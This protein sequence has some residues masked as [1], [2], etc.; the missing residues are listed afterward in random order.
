MSTFLGTV[1]SWPEK[2]LTSQHVISIFARAHTGNV[3]GWAIPSSA[4]LLRARVAASGLDLVTAFPV[5]LVDG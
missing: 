1:H 5:N 3:G 4:P 2:G